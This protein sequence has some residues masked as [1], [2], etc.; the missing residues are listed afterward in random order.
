MVKTGPYLRNT[1]KIINIKI[2][3]LCRFKELGIYNENEKVIEVLPNY[4]IIDD[5]IV[6]DSALPEENLIYCKENDIVEERTVKKYQVN[7][8]PDNEP[9]KN[10]IRSTGQLSLILINQEKKK[11]SYEINTCTFSIVKINDD[12]KIL[13]V[14]HP[15]QNFI[16]YQKKPYKLL[17]VFNFDPLDCHNIFLAMLD[18]IAFKNKTLE[19]AYELLKSELNNDN[20]KFFCKF[21]GILNQKFM[22]LRRNIILDNFNVEK[23]ENIL[24]DPEYYLQPLPSIDA[25]LLDIDESFKSYLTNNQIFGIEICKNYQENFDTDYFA[26]G[27][28]DVKGTFSDE[29]YSETLTLDFPLKQKNFVNLN[30][31]AS[32]VKLKIDNNHIITS[33]SS[34]LEGSSGAPILTIDGQ[35]VAMSFAY[36]SDKTSFEKMECSK[37]LLLFDKNVLEEELSSYNK[38]K[39]SNLAISLKHLVFS[40]FVAQSSNNVSYNNISSNKKKYRK[41]ASEN[42]I[43]NEKIVELE[44]LVIKGEK[45]GINN[46]KPK[47][48]KHSNDLSTSS[49]DKYFLGKK[50]LRSLGNTRN[51]YSDSKQNLQNYD[52]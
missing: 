38:S 48:N 42:I 19:S 4:E 26:I 41:N 9:F 10:A 8:I 52:Q 24:L 30:K 43:R 29:N 50:H 51:S 2:G 37:D 3:F 23:K 28:N 34:L 49:A 5:Q 7:H 31:S 32:V 22:D 15:F 16:Q 1:A 13:T 35:I 47:S 18:K 46:Q 12:I 20:T 6:E 17:T 39:N 33:I 11:I 21:N 27:Y 36:Y 44:K 14:L 40:E 45:N 25:L